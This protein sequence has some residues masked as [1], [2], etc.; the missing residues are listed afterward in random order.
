MFED[1]QNSNG[2][3]V[4]TPQ[5]ETFEVADPRW[6]YPILDDIHN[7]SHS[8]RGNLD[9]YEYLG[10]EDEALA[11]AFCPS[12]H[13]NRIVGNLGAPLRSIFLEE[14]EVNGTTASLSRR[15]LSNPSSDSQAVELVEWTS[16]DHVSGTRM[17][18]AH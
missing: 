16:E 14:E 1:L 10:P 7:K 6:E 13:Y 18:R 2:G 8:S 4:I 12:P 5:S 17:G 15:S 9:Y 3:L 11:S